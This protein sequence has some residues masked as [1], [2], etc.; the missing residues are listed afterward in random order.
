MERVSR[1]G[2][3]GGIGVS[4]FVAIDFET[5]DHGA[6]SACAVGLVRVEEG[7]IVRRETRLI[8][9]PRCHFAFTH[10]HGISWGDVAHQPCFAEVWA[11][12]ED[13]LDGVQCLAAH[14]AG[15]D[16]SVLCACCQSAG[17]APPSLAFLCTVQIARRL[18]RIHP[19]KLSNVCARLGFPLDHHNALSDAE[20]CARIMIAAGPS[21]R[22]SSAGRLCVA[23]RAAVSSDSSDHGR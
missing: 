17:I 11:E 23:S 8:R 20:A 7:R 22:V 2:G 21:V 4:T 6:D 5:A 3:D 1:D 19:T 18:W 16:R 10:I 14:N 9:P 12:L 15:F 13:V